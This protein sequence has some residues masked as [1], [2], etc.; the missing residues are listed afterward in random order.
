MVSTKEQRQRYKKKYPEKV[1]EQKQRY[2][3]RKLRKA[4][5]EN[6]L[7]LEKLKGKLLSEFDRLTRLIFHELLPKRCEICLTTSD[8][9]IHH[10]RYSFPIEKNDLIR[11]CRKCHIRE[12]QRPIPITEREAMISNGGK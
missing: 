5:K 3:D 8:I 2:L 4:I 9:H 7:Y 10:L 1:R 12:H 6:P 11:L